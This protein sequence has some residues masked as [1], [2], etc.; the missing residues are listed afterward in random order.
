[1]VLAVIGLPKDHP[2]PTQ[3]VQVQR[4]G[5]RVTQL[6]PYYT[7]VPRARAPQLPPRPSP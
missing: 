5:T 6:L 1:M 2:A 7:L 3:H 4:Q